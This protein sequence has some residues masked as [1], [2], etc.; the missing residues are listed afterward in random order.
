MVYDEQIKKL[1]VMRLSTMPPNVSFS[2]GNYGKFSRE[3]LIKEVKKNSATG[4]AI[5]S[6]E[7]DLLRQMPHLSAQLSE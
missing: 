5:V 2:I 3:D 4:E 7:I 6:M 1:V